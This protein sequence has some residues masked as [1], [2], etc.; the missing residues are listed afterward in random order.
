MESLHASPSEFNYIPMSRHIFIL[1]LWIPTILF[2]QDL[3][4]FYKDGEINLLSDQDYGK[5]N[6]WNKIFPDYSVTYRG[7][8]T[9]KNKAIVV[10]P[11]GSVFMSHHTRHSI[12]K[13]DKTGNYITDFG[14]KGGKEGDFVYMPSVQGILDGKY[15]YTTAVDGRM[16]FF[17]LNGKWIK[18]IRLKYMP[19]STTPLKNGKIAI[20]GYVPWNGGSKE[21]ISLLNFG[22][23]SEKIL[24]SK[25]KSRTENNIIIIKTKPSGMMST[26]L[27]FTHS[28]YFRMRLATSKDG[29][30]VIGYPA[31]GEIA[32]Y[33]NTGQKLKQFKLTDIKPDA[34][35]KE[36][37][38]RYH[39]KAMENITRL[40]ATMDTTKDTKKKESL[41][42]YISQ[43]KPQIE[44]FR[45]PA[46][47]PTLPYFSE[48]I[49]DS[50]NNILLFRFTREEGSNQFDVYSYNTQGAKIATSKF[51]ANDY[52]LK[53]NPSAF[54]F[55]NKD[56]YSIVELKNTNNN[57]LRLVKF[58][59]QN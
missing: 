57:P 10:A 39:Q 3:V 17:D 42:S 44:K 18:T 15:L 12:S 56:I 26:A 50:D 52:L 59:L 53:I 25:I 30:L 9:G 13:F 29:D 58:R 40:E 45:D 49:V 46:N 19:L 54:R 11:D 22:D 35:S 33:N 8:K 51:L 20:L 6:D 4:S 41:R 7:K 5:T 16:H 23:G 34:I 21:I 55:H 36:D 43:Y 38:E 28:M 47:Y 14:K 27:P 24:M 2:S 48:M 37:M 31:T 32:F 1:I